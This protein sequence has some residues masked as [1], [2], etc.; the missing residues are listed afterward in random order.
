MHPVVRNN[1]LA[2]GSSGI[3]GKQGTCM[4]IREHFA[5]KTLVEPRLIENSC[6]D[7]LCIRR[8]VR[9]PPQARNHG[10]MGIGFPGVLEVHA[11]IALAW[12]PPNQSLLLKLRRFS[13]QEIAQRQSGVLRVELEFTCSI[14]ARQ[15]IGNGMDV[16][17]SESNLMPSP[18]PTDVLG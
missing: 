6:L 4:R 12:V 1:R 18:R 2:L 10:P 14:C 3:A 15:I 11:Y 9:L 13:R 5:V 8:Y 7:V 16:I 17:H